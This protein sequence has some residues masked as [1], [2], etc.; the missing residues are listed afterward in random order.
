MELL[1]RRVLW[2]SGY[3]GLI[4]ALVGGCRAE[5]PSTP[6]E[7]IDGSPT[8]RPP[9]L[10]QGVEDPAVATVV[11]VTRADAVASSSDAASCIAA[12]GEADGA[13]VERIGVNGRS[14]TFLGP[15]RRTVHACDAGA[16][17]DSEGDRWCGHAFAQV[18]SG[19]PRDRRLSLTCRA[20]DGDPVGFMW[21][22]PGAGTEFIVVR[23]SGYTEVY[24]AAGDVPVRVTTEMVDFESSRAAFSI[25]EHAR[26]GRLL[27]S[28]DLE[29][30]V[31]G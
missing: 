15:G 7:L 16:V 29:A 11:R 10:L 14:I 1:R 26:S 5:T 22:Q 9:V 13:V 3:V 8:R 25:S 19:R 6:S 27:R 2:R 20:P 24:A 23:G 21:I 4:L 12:M 30:Q 17:S 28:D 18:G 31:A